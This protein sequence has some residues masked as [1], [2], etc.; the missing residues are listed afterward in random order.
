MTQTHPITLLP[1][2][3]DT[4]RLWQRIPRPSNLIQLINLSAVN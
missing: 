3:V 2:T 4:E 1:Y